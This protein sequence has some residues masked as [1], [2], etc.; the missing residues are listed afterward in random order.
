MTLFLIVF[1]WQIPHFLSIAWIY[2]D[3]YA[4][5]GLRMLPVIDPSGRLTGKEMVL[6]SMTLIPVSLTPAFLG[7]ALC[8]VF[9][10]VLALGLG[11]LI[12]TIGFWRHGEYLQARRVLKASLVYLPALLVLLLIDLATR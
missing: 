8:S 10:G 9:G 11:F 2:R 12:T 5:A 1:V 4:R 6:Y 3:D 7:A